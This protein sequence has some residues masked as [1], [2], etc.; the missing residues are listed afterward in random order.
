MAGFTTVQSIGAAADLPSATRS[1]A[2]TSQ[3]RASSPRPP[4]SPTRPSPDQIRAYV[5]KTA[6]DGADV[7]KIFAPNP[8]ARAAARLSPTR[9]SAPPAARRARRQAHLG[10]RARGLR[11][12][13]LG[14]GRLHRR[15]ARLSDRRRRSALMAQR[16][17]F[18]EPQTGLLLQNYIENKP[19]FFGIG[20][21]NE[22]ASSLWKTRSR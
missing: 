22:A 10:A 13:R 18:F 21:Y 11:G 1:R 14:D 4:R 6:A 8:S 20:N 15:H 16:G 19:R 7:I 12:P 5:R 17:T 3:A 2:E 9:R